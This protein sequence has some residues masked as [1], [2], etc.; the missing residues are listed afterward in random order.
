V[1]F[2]EDLG[3]DLVYAPSPWEIHPDHRQATWLV[4]EAMKRIKHYMRLA[5]YEI[6]APLRPN[7]LLD[8]TSVQSAKEVAMQAFSSQQERQDFSGQIQAL[9]KYRTYSLPSSVKAVEAYWL[10]EQNDWSLLAKTGF[11]EL[12]SP[13]HSL[14]LNPPAHLP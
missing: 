13:G 7:V 11:S 8:I 10:L 9:N 5:F 3:A 1:K 6:G 2:I 14:Q 4:I 12:V